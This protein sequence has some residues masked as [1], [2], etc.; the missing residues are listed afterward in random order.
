MKVPAAWR[1][2]PLP[3]GLQPGDFDYLDPGN[4]FWSY[5]YGLASA[6][7]FRGSRDNTIAYKSGGT[8]IVG[9]SGGFQ[10]GKGTGEIKAWSSLGSGG[11]VAKKWRE[12][13]IVEEIVDWIEQYATAG[14]SL[15]LPLWSARPTNQ[16]SPFSLCD[17]VALR[18][19]S[20]EH[21]QYLLDRKQAGRLSKKYLNVLQGEE[22]ADEETWYQEARKYK[23]DGWSLAGRVG[24]D[25]GPYRIVRR[26]LRLRDDKLLERGADWVHLLKQTQPR[27][28]PFLT[29]LQRGLQKSLGREEFKIT[30]DSSTPYQE[31]GAR[32][33]YAERPALGQSVADWRFKFHKFPTS[34]GYANSTVSMALAHGQC[35]SA[36]CAVCV[37]GKAHLPAPM[38]SP[39]AQKLSVQDLL[40][41]KGSFATRHGD[42]LFDETLINHNVYVVV[43]GLI[44]ANEAIFSAK[45]NAPQQLV[46]A[47]GLVDQILTAQKWQSVLAQHRTALEKA[48]GF[49]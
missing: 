9:D 42:A 48:V 17:E 44:R 20:M 1:S 36:K 7:A 34:Y 45:P 14:L 41:R 40:I 18:E 28:A 25:G 24:T 32:E 11:L 26:L 12:R 30:F 16:G 38:D 6:E 5:A 35:G 4:R 13:G 47:V 3:A 22:E 10:F 23:L 49:R 33:R 31:A 46:D 15:D 39:I 37:R 8:V 19:M 27:W 2:T 21:V 29:A 43:E